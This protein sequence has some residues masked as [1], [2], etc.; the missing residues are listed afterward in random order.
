MLGLPVARV[1][2]QQADLPG[3]VIDVKRCLHAESH[4]Y[5]ASCDF[6]DACDP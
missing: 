2:I 1:L 3:V 5:Q 4:V 6:S